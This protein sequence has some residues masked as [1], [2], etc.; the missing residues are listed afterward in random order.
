MGRL[1]GKV[2]FITGAARGQGRSHALRLAEEGADIIAV[3][4]WNDFE[5]VGYPMGTEAELN[6]TARLIE[7]YDRRVLI[8]PVDVRDRD[9]LQEFVDEATQQIGDIDIVCANAGILPRAAAF[10]EASRQEWQDVLDVNLV[11]VWNA[12]SAVAPRMMARKKGGSIVI[13]SSSAGL[14]APPGLGTYNAAK[15]GV[16]KSRL[17]TAAPKKQEKW[18]K[19][20]AP[21]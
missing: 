20:A 11:G 10:F 8:R 13:T 17:K 5:S 1:D 9:G 12:V 3:D 4:H 6:E 16:C 19:T 15:H 21:K 2:A 14:R 18:S 7:S